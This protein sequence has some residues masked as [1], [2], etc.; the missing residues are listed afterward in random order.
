[1]AMLVV[2]ITT[3]QDISVSDVGKTAAHEPL[4]VAESG[5]SSSSAAVASR[6]RAFSLNL[7]PVFCNTC[8]YR[9]FGIQHYRAYAHHVRRMLQRD[10]LLTFAV[11]KALSNLRLADSTPVS[12]VTPDPSGNSSALYA[13]RLTPCLWGTAASVGPASNARSGDSSSRMRLGAAADAFKPGQLAHLHSDP[14]STAATITSMQCA[15]LIEH[16]LP[17][18]PTEV[19]PRLMRDYAVLSHVPA[20][21]T[22]LDFQGKVSSPCTVHS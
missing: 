4:T 11:Q 1:M 19:M 18:N 8:C 6:R 17:C 10:P 21:L 7:V 14:T 16:N 12:H 3:A 15:L 13:M 22:L 2:G 20:I 5:P 9:M